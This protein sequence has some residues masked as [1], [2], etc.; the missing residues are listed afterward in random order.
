VSTNKR[1]RL[2][3]E[4]SM[5]SSFIAVDA[6]S[7]SPNKDEENQA[8]VSNVLGGRSCFRTSNLQTDTLSHLIV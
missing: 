5:A 2:E 8:A 6:A 7:P 4:G 3:D 1:R